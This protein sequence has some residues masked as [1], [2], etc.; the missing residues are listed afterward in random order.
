MRGLAFRTWIVLLGLLVA[1]G[2]G[3]PAPAAPVDRPLRVASA[4]IA[5]EPGLAGEQ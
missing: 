2:M 4:G 3:T 1:V 5:A